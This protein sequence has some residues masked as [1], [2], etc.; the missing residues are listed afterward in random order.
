[1]LSI[2]QMDTGGHAA[3]HTPA[4]QPSIRAWQEAARA[5]ALKER[6]APGIWSIQSARHA[7]VS[8]R[9]TVHLASGTSTCNCPA[10]SYGRDCHHALYA[11]AQERAIVAAEHAALKAKMLRDLALLAAGYEEWE[12]LFHEAVQD[13]AEAV[14]V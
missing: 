2:Q 12:G 3:V 9:V 13:Y 11:E 7:A 8:Y 14:I 6:I 5:A 10:G 4:K 1:M